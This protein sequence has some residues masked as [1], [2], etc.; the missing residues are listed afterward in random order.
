MTISL[1]TLTQAA[2]AGFACLLL[3][4]FGYAWLWTGNT[5]LLSTQGLMVTAE[6]LVLCMLLVSYCNRSQL[7]LVAY[8]LLLMGIYYWLPIINLIVFPDNFLRGNPL[9][10]WLKPGDVDAALG[11]IAVAFPLSLLVLMA[12]QRRSALGSLMIFR[13]PETAIRIYWGATILMLESSAVDMYRY[14]V[15]GQGRFG[16][17][18]S[19]GWNWIFYL[20][21]EFQLACIIFFAAAVSAWPLIGKK[22]K[23]IFAITLSSYVVTRALT[24]SKGSIFEVFIF[25][26]GAFLLTSDI[27][28]IKVKL[29]GMLLA[30]AIVLL[31]LS[32]VVGFVTRSVTFGGELRSEAIDVE[33]IYTQG[34]KTYGDQ[35]DIFSPINM[36]RRMA[37]RVN[38]LDVLVLIIHKGTD[39]KLDFWDTVPKAIVNL[40]M[41]G[42][43]FENILASSRLFMVEYDGQSEETAFRIYHTDLWYL[44]GVFIP[45]VGVAGALIL[46]ALALWAFASWYYHTFRLQE[47]W[48]FYSVVSMFYCFYWFIVNLGVDEWVGIVGKA[49]VNLLFF[50]AAMHVFEKWVP[51]KLLLASSNRHQS[52]TAGA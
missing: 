27:D 4:V 50:V 29:L 21:S 45:F 49:T 33:D 38:A 46:V 7:G 51:R 5:G 28:R 30:S 14:L 35:E 36:A 44:Y 9:S 1:K 25:G 18:A 19:G 41:P 22:G 2:L 52:A 24:G 34:V 40:L 31:P 48:R 3:L 12:C 17:G 20:I 26:I 23:L 11:F 13:S 47:R 32:F 37:G 39:T 6:S 8:F 10:F 16:E 43:P 42:D 15:V